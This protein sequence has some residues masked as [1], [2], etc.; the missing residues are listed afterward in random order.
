MMPVIK[1]PPPALLLIDIQK[2]H[3]E[4][5][6]YGGRRN[7]PEAEQN[8][9]RLLDHWRK[10]GW[11]VFHIKHNSTDKNSPLYIG[12]QGNEI[13]EIVQPSKDEPIIEK[14]VN[15]AFI[16][17]DLEDQLLA[18]GITSVVIAGLTIEH[19]VSTTTRMAS[20]LGFE[21]ILISDATAAFDKNGPMELSISA[22]NIYN[23]E[24]ACLHKDLAQCPPDQPLR[25]RQECLPALLKTHHHSIRR[26]GLWPR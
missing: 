6:Y 11:P 9:R 23:A 7:N 14:N 26:P 18:S 15:C 17:T 19:C 25:R 20:D 2:G 21:T 12:N 1:D 8:A 22:E 24:L 13:K 4:L 10:S 3:D 16:G 5:E